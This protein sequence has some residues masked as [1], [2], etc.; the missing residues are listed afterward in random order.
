M[1]LNHG[2]DLPARAEVIDAATR[3][4]IG[5][6][7]HAG[8]GTAI[9]A[10]PGVSS[11]RSIGSFSK[12][13][14]PSALR[15]SAPALTPGRAWQ[16]SW[17]RVHWP[18][19]AASASCRDA[20]RQNGRSFRVAP[21]LPI[22]AVTIGIIFASSFAVGRLPSG[23]LAG[24]IGAVAI[25]WVSSFGTR[26][27]PVNASRS[28]DVTPIS[29]QDRDFSEA[30]LPFVLVSRPSGRPGE[31]R[32]H[33][34]FHPSVRRS[35]SAVSFVRTAHRR[36]S[37]RL[38]GTRSTT[39]RSG[40]CSS[41][42]ASGRRFAAAEAIRSRQNSR[43]GLNSIRPRTRPHPP[44]KSSPAAPSATRRR[45]CQ[46]TGRHMTPGVPPAARSSALKHASSMRT[47]VA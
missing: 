5:S 27:L 34:A 38:L 40:S 4:T 10:H 13:V 16:R 39:R 24:D 3:W 35:D 43:P 7:H 26:R 8:W 21:P 20:R 17:M 25:D 11:K 23:R 9:G 12:R 45:S 44:R 2:T 19:A 6:T 46:R 32:L 18:H 41:P 47:G 42:R 15:C 31:A 33:V 36:C 1:S 14:A 29:R 37:R 30:P 28:G 22:V